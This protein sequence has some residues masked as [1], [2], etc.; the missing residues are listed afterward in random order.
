M[1]S[2]LQRDFLILTNNVSFS[3][4]IQCS[5]VIERRGFHTLTKNVLSTTGRFP[6]PY[7]ECFVILPLTDTV[8]KRR[9]FH[10]VRKNVLFSS[11]MQFLK[12]E[13]S[14]P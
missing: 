5:A 1:F 4:P 12:G 8:F 7:K 10:T 3:S 14:T 11:P 13:V 9:G 6:R 2:L